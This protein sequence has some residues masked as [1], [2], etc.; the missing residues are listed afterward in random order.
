MPGR[1]S[2]T[3]LGVCQKMPSRPPFS[4]TNT[5]C[6]RV[7]CDR[8][9]T[10]SIARP[11]RRHSITGVSSTTSG[12]SGQPSARAQNTFDVRGHG[13]RALRISGSSGTGIRSR[14]GSLECGSGLWATTNDTAMGARLRP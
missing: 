2:F 10:R 4:V 1:V 11:W 7:C 14:Y 8:S 13:S 5:N 12:R 3:V 9:S 6:D